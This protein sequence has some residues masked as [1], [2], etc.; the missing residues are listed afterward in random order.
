MS[1]E[2]DVKYKKWK[3]IRHKPKCI[4]AQKIMWKG[5]ML[6]CHECPAAEQPTD[7]IVLDEK[8]NPYDLESDSSD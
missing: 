1:T 6:H 4:C 7:R 8:G 2:R 3:D 5:F